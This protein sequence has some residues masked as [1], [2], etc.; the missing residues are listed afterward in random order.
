MLRNPVDLIFL[1]ALAFLGWAWLMAMMGDAPIRLVLVLVLLLAVALAGLRRRDRPLVFY[2]TTVVASLGIQWLSGGEPAWLFLV[3][4]GMFCMEAYEDRDQLRRVVVYGT[5]GT[6]V[7]VSVATSASYAMDLLL[8]ALLVCIVGW[9]RGV[10][11]QRA[12]TASLVQRA[13]AAERERDS[14]AAEAVA[15][16]RARIARDIHD[17]V[18]HSLAVVAV[19]AAGAQRVA[20]RQPERAAEA[21]AVIAETARDALS[22]MRAMLL[23]LRSGDQ[24]TDESQPS[25]G[26]PQLT[27][28]VGDL[29]E[30]GVPVTMSVRGGAYPLGAGAELAVFRVVQES[31][32]NA[33]K[34]GS[35][36]ADRPLSLTLTYGNSDL[37]VEVRSPLR[38]VDDHHPELI[39]GSGS[40]QTGMRER[41]ALYGGDLEVGPTGAEYIVVARVPRTLTAPAVI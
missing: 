15:A 16:E 22:E 24:A 40:G 26:L 27:E 7:A 12:Y 5:L 29:N 13:L 32:T 10:R 28:L 39:P 38:A 8:G 25:P 33:I 11:T 31:L 23:V 3:S 34:H 20:A 6:S 18:S 2:L 41:L 17:L 21:L 14:R 19:Q 37:V 36:G 1:A 4:Y 30:R 9:G 35:V